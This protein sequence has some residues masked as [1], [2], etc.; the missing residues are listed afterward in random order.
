MADTPSGNNKAATRVH[1]LTLSTE[2]AHVR[3]L[4]RSWA[5]GEVSVDDYRMIRSLTIEGML[6]GEFDSQAPSSPAS[7]EPSP[8]DD[9]DHDITA[10]GDKTVTKE[11]ETDPN[12]E[13]IVPPPQPPATSP[14]PRVALIAGAVLL[15]L[16]VILLLSMA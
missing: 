7:G 3:S 1:V 2:S 13:A 10:V 9:V 6:S 12:F 4:A 8:A 15:V 5:A 14:F 16:G 11:D